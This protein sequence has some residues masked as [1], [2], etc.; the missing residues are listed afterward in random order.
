MLQIV[1]IGHNEE[2]KALIQTFVNSAFPHTR[3]GSE[4]T[5][6]F[7]LRWYQRFFT[8]KNATLAIK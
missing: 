4:D 2:A 3:V 5:S 7:Y 1:F 8:D 6:K